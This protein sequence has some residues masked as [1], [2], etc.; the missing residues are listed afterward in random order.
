MRR[1]EF[2]GYGLRGLVVL[3]AQPLVGFGCGGDATPDAIDLH[4]VEALVEMADGSRVYH[5]LFAADPLAPTFPGPVITATAGRAITIHV[6]NLLHEA[7]AFEVPGIPASATGPIPPGGSATVR[8]AIERTGSFLYL[9]PLRAPLHRLLGLHGALV[10]LPRGRIGSPYGDPT[11]AVQR[12]FDDLGTAP[13]FPG[14]P[15]LAERSRI[16]LFHQ[17]DPEL[18]RRVAERMPIDPERIRPNFRP[19]LFTLNGRGGYFAARAADTR[20][21]AF[22]GEPHLVRVLNAG[23]VVLSPHLHGNHGYPVAVDGVVQENLAF[24]DTWT[25]APLQRVDWLLP[26]VA[27]QE[28]GGDPQRPLRERIPEEA[29]APL[30]YPVQCGGGG[31]LATEIVFLGDVDKRPFA[32]GSAG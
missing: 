32:A 6:H 15:W 5:R 16:W 11:P 27:P 13:H 20:I 14:D 8:F 3:A 17:I 18:N 24:A 9:D 10:V 25:V 28:I 23:L 31:E 2:L 7:H 12:L 1:R 4:V 26:F 22:V 21:E 19:R 30:R 29:G